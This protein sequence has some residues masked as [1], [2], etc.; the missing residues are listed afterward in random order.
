MNRLEEISVAGVGFT[1]FEDCS[2]LQRRL[3]WPRLVRLSWRAQCASP[4]D[5]M[6]FSRFDRLEVLGVS[7]RTVQVP[8]ALPAQDEFTP[9]AMRRIRLESDFALNHLS[10]AEV[11]RFA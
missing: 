4:A 5:L 9:T 10:V 1:D 6:A 8:Q 7:L 11:D 2:P 3:Q